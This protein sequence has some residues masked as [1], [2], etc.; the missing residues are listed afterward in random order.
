MFSSFVFAALLAADITVTASN[1]AVQD[2]IAQHRGSPV[3]LHFW[4]T[5]CDACVKEFPHF[6]QVAK[7]PGL[8]VVLVSVDLKQTIDKHVRPFLE[9]QH[10]DFPSLL[11]DVDN[12]ERVMHAI[13]ARWNGAI[14]ASFLYD[15][16]GKLVRRFLGD[17][18]DA[19]EK[20]IGAL[21]NPAPGQ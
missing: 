14:P 7:T 18:G 13:D 3:L 17:K 6:M 8:K 11:L 21:I 12:P 19:L 15:K 20:A 9:Q 16:D 4:A 10:V 2:T 1:T 5:W